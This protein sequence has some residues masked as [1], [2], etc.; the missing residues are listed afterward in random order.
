MTPPITHIHLDPLGGIAGDMFV[1]ALLDAFPD[2]AEDTWAT[3][4]AAGLP[5]DWQVGLAAGQRKGLAGRRLVI[6]PPDPALAAAGDLSPEYKSYRAIRALIEAAPLAPPVQARALDILTIVGTAE[7]TVHGVGLDQVHF[8]ELAG[9]DSLADVVAAAHVIERLAHVTWSVGVLPLGGGRVETAHGPLP[10]PGLAT[11]E[12]LRGFTMVDDGIAG[13]RVTPTGAAI[14]KSLQPTF[15]AVNPAATLAGSGTGLGSK[16]FAGIANALRVLV[17]R[18]AEA[19]LDRDMVGVLEFYVD[20][21][22]PEDLAIALRRLADDPAVLDVQQAA[23]AGRKG[24]LGQA[25]T[26]LCRAAALEATAARCLQETTSIGLRL[27]LSERRLLAR[28]AVDLEAGGRSLPAKRVRRP[29]GGRDAK[30][31]ADA[32]EATGLDRAGRAALRRA[33]AAEETE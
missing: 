26:V 25:V 21:Q 6:A 29:D 4:R 27:R 23:A 18:P 33:A 19:V 12:I 10:M 17:F 9:W 30:L 32:V 1:A 13:E 2:L 24:R 8:H 14:V 22:T 28:E 5:A 15:A 3:M 31:E 16:D 7:A 11:V 20:D